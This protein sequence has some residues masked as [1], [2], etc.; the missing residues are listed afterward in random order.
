VNEFSDED[1]INWF[2]YIN[3]AGTPQDSE[4]MKI[5][6]DPEINLTNLGEII[7]KEIE[8]N[9]KGYSRFNR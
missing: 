3:F 1:K 8:K 4:H 5:L 7:E 2:C 6:S 9:G